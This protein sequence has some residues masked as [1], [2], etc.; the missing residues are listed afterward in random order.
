MRLMKEEPYSQAEA[1]AA[2]GMGS[3]ILKINTKKNELKEKKSK[4]KTKISDDVLPPAS[5]L[6]A[7]VNIFE[8]LSMES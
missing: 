6:S 5:N 3:Y 2:A 8:S 7:T 4:K 1:E